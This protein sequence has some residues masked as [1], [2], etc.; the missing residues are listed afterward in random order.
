MDEEKKKEYFI[1]KVGDSSFIGLDWKPNERDVAYGIDVINP[2]INKYII[3]SDVDRNN[4]SLNILSIPGVDN[5]D[6]FVK[7]MPEYEKDTEGNNVKYK[8]TDTAFSGCVAKVVDNYKENL[9]KGSKKGGCNCAGGKKGSKKSKKG[10]KK[11][12]KKGSKKSKKG[13]K[14]GSKKGSKKSKKGGKK[15]SK[16]GGKKCSKKGSKK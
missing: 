4:N 2:A 5:I 11:G 1:I 3:H 6:D 9:K 16:K 14:K 13:G 8:M 12:S 15:G 7:K 10:G